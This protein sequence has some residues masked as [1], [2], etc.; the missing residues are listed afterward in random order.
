MLRN[1]T[2]LASQVVHGVTG[3]LLCWIWNLWLFLD[4]ANEVSVPLLVV[5][6]S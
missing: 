4:D 1:G 2:P 5:T 6:S 3:H